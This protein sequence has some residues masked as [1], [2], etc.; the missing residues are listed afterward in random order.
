MEFMV[1]LELHIENW[2]RAVVRYDNAHDFA[3]RDILDFT[4]GEIAKTSLKLGTLEEVIEYAEQDLT[5]R[6][7]WYVEKFIKTRK[8][9]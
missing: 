1:Q 2:W 3:H 9:Q 4:G 6:A 8:M 5:D 7:D